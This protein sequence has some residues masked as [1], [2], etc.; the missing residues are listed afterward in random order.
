MAK[1][2]DSNGLSHLI[3][4]LKELFVQK[5]GNKVLSDTNFTQAEKTKL[6]GLENYND[7]DVRN[8]INGKQ[9]TLVSGTNIKTI[10]GNSVMG[11]GDLKI[12]VG[13]SEVDWS[14][15]KNKPSTYAPS[16]HTHAQSEVT[17]LTDTVTNLTNIANGKTASYVFETV[18][19][20]DAE[21]AKT[22]FTA[23]LK[24]GDVFLIVATD[25]PDYW[26]TGSA[27]AQLETT[28]VDLSRIEE[29]DIDK[30]VAG[31]YTE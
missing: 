26:W 9:P 14:D 8:L 31:T 29:T 16:A 13:I 30:M 25:V 24:V 11:S 12:D 20:L 18:A 7:T 1:Y 2:L 10:N 23:K 3:S 28:K 6:A 21:L 27:K 19:A 22:E 5:D 15:V 4:K 17:G